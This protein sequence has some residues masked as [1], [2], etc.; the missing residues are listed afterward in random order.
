LYHTNGT[1]LPPLQQKGAGDYDQLQPLNEEDIDPGS[2]DLVAPQGNEFKQYSLERRSEQVS[3][4]Q[5]FLINHFGQQWQNKR[6]LLEELCLTW[7]LIAL[8]NGASADNF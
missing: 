7:K 8:L 6:P 1:S 3:K 4:I 2:F 5:H